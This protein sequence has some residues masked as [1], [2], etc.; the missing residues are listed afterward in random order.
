MCVE[1]KHKVSDKFLIKMCLVHI[2]NTLS[3]DTN[4]CTIKTKPQKL[5]LTLCARRWTLA[6]QLNDDQL[7]FV[8]IRELARRNVLPLNLWLGLMCL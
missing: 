1:K 7:S 8:L 6:A 3:H 4:K 2:T 5:I